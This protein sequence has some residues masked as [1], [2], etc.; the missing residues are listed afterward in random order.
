MR[1][2][3]NFR[4]ALTK[5]QVLQANAK[6]SICSRW[7]LGYSCSLTSAL[8][9][10]WLSW[11]ARVHSVLVEVGRRRAWWLL[12]LNVRV[13]PQQLKRNRPDEQQDDDGD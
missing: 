13:P 3:A 1:L 12:N 6:M 2:Q 7:L 11:A 9:E 4:R 10:V 5:E 8:F